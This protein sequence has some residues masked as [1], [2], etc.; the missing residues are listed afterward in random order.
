MCVKSS[1]KE[2]SILKHSGW[3]EVLRIKNPSVLLSILVL[4]YGV[5]VRE[6]A[7]VGKVVEKKLFIAQ[8]KCSPILECSNEFKTSEYLIKDELLS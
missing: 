6:E 8:K 4:L 5:F 7:G 1:R 2:H 3:S